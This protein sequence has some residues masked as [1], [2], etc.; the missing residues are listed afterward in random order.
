M[1]PHHF[2]SETNFFL[3]SLIIYIYILI[4]KKKVLDSRVEEG[5]G[6]D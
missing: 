5:E 2:R 1:I 6:F 4:S 3:S